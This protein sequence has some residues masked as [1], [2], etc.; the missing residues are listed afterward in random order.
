MTWLRVCWCSTPIWLHALSLYVITTISMQCCR[1]WPMCAGQPLQDQLDGRPSS[2]ATAT[3][4][5]PL[6]DHLPDSNPTFFH[7]RRFPPNL[8]FS[9]VFSRGVKSIKKWRRKQRRRREER[10]KQREFTKVRERERVN[11]DRVVK[12]REVDMFCE[13]ERENW[14]TE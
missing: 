2:R 6:P 7:K 11:R 9:S 13:R 4:A 3:G 1:N 14:K 5:E 8:N 10:E 12:E